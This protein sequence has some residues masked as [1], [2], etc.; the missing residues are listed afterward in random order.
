MPGTKSDGVK[1]SR[2]TPWPK[3][4]KPWYTRLW[5]ALWSRLPNTNFTALPDSKSLPAATRFVM[6]ALPVGAGQS[7][8][9]TVDGVPLNL[10]AP[11]GTRAGDMHEYSFTNA[12][13]Q[14]VGAYIKQLPLEDAKADKKVERSKPTR[15][16]KRMAGWGALVTQARRKQENDTY[17]ANGKR[18]PRE[19]FRQWVES[20][21]ESDPR[22]QIRDFFRR[23]DRRGPMGY[24]KAIES[25]P[26][27]ETFSRF[28]AVWRP[29]SMDAIRMMMEGRATGKVGSKCAWHRCRDEALL[30]VAHV[31]T[32]LRPCA[33]TQCQ[34]QVC[35]ERRHLG[36]CAVYS[37]PRGG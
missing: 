1:S 29:T 11:P 37:D 36:L 25:E 8:D 16:K 22:H 34:G 32:W 15:P 4:T 17:A 5:A 31:T 28:F 10:T 18:N 26:D 9:W 20:V 7:F 21:I 23:G 6:I 13:G 3:P 24:L 14:I 30:H 19:S 27:G 12:G 33:G 35:Q 2:L